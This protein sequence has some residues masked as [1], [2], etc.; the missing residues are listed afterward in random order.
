MENEL[1]QRYISGNATLEEKQTFLCWIEADERHMQE[2]K[3]CRKSYDVQLWHAMAIQAKQKKTFHINRYVRELIKVAAIFV[4][5]FGLTYT[6]FALS[7]KKETIL[8][9]LHV[10]AGQRAELLLADGTKVWLHAMTTLIFPTQF[11][12]GKREVTLDGE[13][14]FDVTTDEINP[15]IV[16]TE[17]HDLKVFGTEFNATAY[18]QTND[19]STSLLKGKIDVIA[20]KTGQI[21]HL[22]PGECAYDVNGKLYKKSISYTDYFRWREGLLCFNNLRMDLLLDKLQLC[23]GIKIEI[24]NKKILKN[25]YT[26]KFRTKDGVEHALRVL[27]LYNSFQFIKDEVTNVICIK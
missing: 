26:G 13:G 4:I 20:K 22:E 5:S 8:Q 27:Q 24:Q 1:L 3:E 10:P 25:Y 23:Y 21:I 11:E 2:F 18:K 15:F 6:L 19:F 12:D 9:T 14:Y 17:L 16:K 7:D